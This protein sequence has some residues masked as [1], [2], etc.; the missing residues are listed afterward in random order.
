MLEPWRKAF[1]EA[2]AMGIKIAVCDDRGRMLACSNIEGHTA[3]GVERLMGV[4]WHDFLQP[5]DM[6]RVLAWF[7]CNCGADREECH[8][9]D[10]ITYQQLS[11]YNGKPVMSDVTLIKYWHGG[12]WLCYGR[13][14]PRA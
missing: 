2:A 8:K 13:V 7:A 12:A 6:P 14:D 11:R 4:G 10:M 1:N 3:A 9:C 5:E